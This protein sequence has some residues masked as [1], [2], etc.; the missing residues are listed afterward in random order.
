MKSPAPKPG[1]M[2]IAPYVAG[3]S[4]AKPGAKIIKLS[5]NESPLGPSPKAVAAYQAVLPKLSRYPDS[6][7][8]ELREAIGQV[9]GMD[10][11]RIVCGAGSDE[12]IGLLVHAYTVPGDEVLYSEHGFLMYKIYAQAAGATPVT[13]PE[14]NL[15]ANVDALLNKVTQKTRIVFLANP[16]NPTG[17]YLPAREVKRLR[18]NLPSH[19]LLAIDGAYTEYV[20]ATDYTSG[21][22]LVDAGDNTVMLRTFSKIYALPSLRIGWGYFPALIADVLNRVRG[23]FNLGT[24]AIAAGAA[25]IRDTESLKRAVEHNH[26]WLA[27]LTQLLRG[28]GLNV[29]PSVGNFVLVEFP[30]DG[31]HTAAQ[32]NEYL[33]NQGI[34]VR[35]VVNYGLPNFLRITVGLKQENEAVVK[36]LEAFL[37]K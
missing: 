9:Q 12:L 17:S 15:T 11:A 4:T 34:I 20:T 22:E 21:R 8:T 30:V 3:K 33:M 32:A 24:P 37:A 5:S 27:W 35:D 14:T 2:N 6:Q 26:H 16:N 28:L 1:I 36:A 29:Y 19:I 18:D 23:P 25:A 13:A 7:H 10:P 31:K